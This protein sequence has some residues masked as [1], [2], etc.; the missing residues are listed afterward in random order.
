VTRAL[1][2]D[3]GEVL[4]RPAFDLFDRL[5]PLIHRRIDGRGPFA[6]DG[7]AR[8]Q[9]MQAGEITTEQYWNHVAESAGVADWRRLFELIGRH[10]PIEMFDSA[11][12]E[13]ADEAKAAGHPIGI[14]SN[15]MVAISGSEWV[16]TNPALARF[17]AIVDAT[18]IGYRKPAPEAYAAICDAL[19]LEPK[20]LVFLDDTPACIEGAEAFGMRGVLV[21]SFNRAP[22]RD[23][24]RA[25]LARPE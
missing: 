24:A 4:T 13:F 1:V 12:L 2:F 15:D 5:E 21:D 18:E 19:Q 17:D 8:W 22:A 14:L 9:Q 23:I 6:P 3:V 10:F 11:M 7:D 25:W 16:R 20:D